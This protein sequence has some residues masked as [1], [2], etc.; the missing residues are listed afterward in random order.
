[1]I[2]AGDD[3]S[4]F[5][6][7]FPS[8]QFNH[9]IVAVP[10]GADTLWLEC[11]SQ[12]NP[13]GY[14]GS[15]TGDRKA[16][17]IT[18]TGAKVVS[19]ARYTAEQNRKSRI[20]DVYVDLSG[21]A[22]A[23]IKT[24]YSGLQYENNNLHFRL[25]N[26]YDEQKKWIQDNT[27]IPSFDIKSFAMTDHKNKIPA[28]I[29]KLDLSLR[30]YASVTGKRIFLTPNLMNRSTYIPEKVDERKT[31]VVRKTAYTDLDTIRYHLPEG[32]YPEFLPEPVT[33][34]SRF[35]EY[36][37][38]FNVEQGSLVYIRKVKMNKGEFP[39]AS[40]QELIDFLKAINRADNTKLVFL[41]K[42]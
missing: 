5:D 15:F 16:L 14:Q 34:N 9:A 19:T 39:A 40:Y 36:K 25:T 20:A 26:Q 30:R 37:A 35:G 42:T 10:N 32:I 4:E 38:T 29:V 24:T 13:F 33:L 41:S 7:D 6:A 17:L 8:S 11:T 31:N 21:D 1:L 2:E 23:T 12:T 27:S 3:H 28:A 22:N 18:E